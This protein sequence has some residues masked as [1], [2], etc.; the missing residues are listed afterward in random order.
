MV[1]VCGAD[2]AAGRWIEQDDVGIAAD[3]D[4]ALRRQ[5]EPARRGRCKQVD[6][7]LDGQVAGADALGRDPAAGDAFAVKDRQECL[8]AGRAV[9]DLIE[10]HS[11][12]CF[13]LLDREAVWDVVRG[14]EVE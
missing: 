7:P 6:H 4:R 8:D 1:E 11:A 14:D 12:G 5:S 3:L 9:A 2:R 10:G 13:G